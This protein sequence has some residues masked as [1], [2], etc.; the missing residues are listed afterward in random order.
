MVVV[1]NIFQILFD[2]DK[3]SDFISLVVKEIF[4]IYTVFERF[5]YYTIL[6]LRV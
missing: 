2:H 1:E 5:D 4:L 6:S 3:L